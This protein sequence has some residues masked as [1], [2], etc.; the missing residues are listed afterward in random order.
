MK[1]AMATLSAAV[2]VTTAIA[3]ATVPA[4][5][6][7]KASSKKILVNEQFG[8][9]D[10]DSTWTDGQTLGRWQVV[11]AGFGSVTRPA[12][13]PRSLRLS[14]ARAQ[15]AGETH[16]ALVVSRKSFA[17]RCLDVRTRVIVREQLRAGSTPNPWETAWLVWDYLDNEHFSY[18]AIKTNGWEL[19]KRDPAYPGGQRFL[20]TGET[21]TTAAGQWRTARIK[22]TASADGLRS[23][24]RAFV[25]GVNVATFRDT[26]RPYVSGKLGMYVEDATADFDKIVASSC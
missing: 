21:P 23:T 11:F 22:R 24:V 1:S 6:A 10:S 14:P 13:R 5:A 19:G 4:S 15:S 17:N 2:L 25:G 12:T 7:T 26:E 3:A 20:A 8:S 16:A 18:L 9:L